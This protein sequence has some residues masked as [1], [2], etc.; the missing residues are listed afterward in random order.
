MSTTQFEAPSVKKVPLVGTLFMK[1]AVQLAPKED[2]TPRVMGVLQVAVADDV[3]RITDF[4][5]QHENLI[6]NAPIKLVY[7]ETQVV[8]DG[9][10]NVYRN[11]V[12]A[13]QS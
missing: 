12:T 11:L 5:R 3:I 10:V 4:S 1:D 8:K 6:E 7:E 2:G 9:R 13:I